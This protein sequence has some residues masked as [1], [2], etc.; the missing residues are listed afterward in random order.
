LLDP[1]LIV[2]SGG[3]VQNNA[4]LLAGLSRELS[5]TVSQWT[6]RN[7]C[8]TASKLGYHVGVFGAAAIAKHIL[9]DALDSLPAA[10]PSG[11]GLE[12]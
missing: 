7:L 8:I 10:P 3:L 2:V 5:Q 12:V 9:E 1:E 11:S 6:K 4:R